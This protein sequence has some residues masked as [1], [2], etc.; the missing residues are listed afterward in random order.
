M[1][2]H[3][4][5]D[6]HMSGALSQASAP[7]NRAERLDPARLRGLIATNVGASVAFA[8]MYSTQPVLPQIGHD[9]QVD[10]ATAG[11]TL[12]AVT[13]ALAFASLGAGRISD[14]F[15]SRRVMLVCS[16]ALT[17]LSALA[18]IAP[19][20][21]LLVATR[22][23]QGLVIPGITVSGLAY[24]HNDLPASW[25]GRV[26]GFY[27]GT[28]TIGGLVGRLGVGLVV[29]TI[30][31]RG[32]L[33]LIAGMVAVGTLILVF[34]MP[35]SAPHAQTATQRKA[36]SPEP[37]LLSITAR[38]WWA[39]LIGAS[40]FFPF[41]TIFTYT[42][43]RLEG[44]PF[45]LSPS[46]AN[47]F[48][49]VY[50]LGAVASLAAGQ[51]SDRI[52]RRTTIYLGLAICAFGLLLSLVNLLPTALLALALVC[53][54][55]LS[56]HVVANASVS[57]GANPLGAGARA[58]ALSLY[59][60]GFYIGGGLGAF[61]PGFGWENWGWPGVIAPCIVALL[62]A[63]LFALKTPLR[64]QRQAAPDIEPAAAP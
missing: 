40:V 51:I 58:T 43:Y 37:S 4:N 38:L 41:I 20:F 55:G 24:L 31:W 59:T 21:G 62:C 27:I 47:L 18:A 39:P 8:A 1:D 34:G 56:S 25:R 57:D 12:L 46:N 35:R 44:A 42:P 2:A 14:H 15:G 54:G 29:E 32:G 48:Y 19:T 61:I 23:A 22:A 10:A 9:F 17:A 7:S 52:G 26:S 30:S 3:N 11:L 36:Q 45:F 6:P 16:A 49:L 5:I 13:F 53:A 63:G 28:N 50:I 60:M 33:A 64:P